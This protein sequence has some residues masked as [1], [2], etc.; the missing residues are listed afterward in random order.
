MAFKWTLHHPL[1]TWPSMAWDDGCFPAFLWQLSGSHGPCSSTLSWA[2]WSPRCSNGN[3]LQNIGHEDETARSILHEMDSITGYAFKKHSEVH[4]NQFQGYICKLIGS[5]LKCGTRASCFN[6]W[7]SMS[8][9]AEL[10]W[11]FSSF[12]DFPPSFNFFISVVEL[13]VLKDTIV[14][15]LCIIYKELWTTYF[16][17]EKEKPEHV[18]NFRTR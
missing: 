3:L 2:T 10:F 12:Y 18:T 8:L 11:S 4:L 1:L 14:C 7:T 13:D 6:W 9:A 5:S 15:D 17:K 16:K